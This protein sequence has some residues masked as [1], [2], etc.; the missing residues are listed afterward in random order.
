MKVA[1][2]SNGENLDAQ[3]DPRFGRCHFFLVVNPDDMSFEAVNNESAAQGGGAGIQ[4]AQFL[5]SQKV[6][7]VITGNCGPNAVQ[8]LSAAGIQVFG[9]QA[10]T[11]RQVV[12]RFKNGNLKP[13]REATVDRPS[14]MNTATGSGRWG[15]C[16]F[17]RA[18]SSSSWPGSP[19]STPGAWGPCQSPRDRPSP[20]PPGSTGA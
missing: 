17:T 13:T 10:G 9:G 19:F 4:A 16:S 7:A 8:T 20:A 1:V 3:L 14:R 2:S 6:A 11:V 5:A 18:S 15:S 12:E